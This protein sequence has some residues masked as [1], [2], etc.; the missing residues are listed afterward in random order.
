MVLL[1]TNVSPELSCHL[2]SNSSG[3]IWTSQDTEMSI[4]QEE[5]L[6]KEVVGCQRR[7]PQV[8]QPSKICLQLGIGPEAMN[9]GQ[10]HQTG[11]RN[12]KPLKKRNGGWHGE[13]CQNGQ[14]QY[15]RLEKM[16][17]GLKSFFLRNWFSQLVILIA[18]VNTLMKFEA[19]KFFW[20]RQT[21]MPIITATFWMVSTASAGWFAHQV[22]AL[23]M[24][25]TRTGRSLSHL[26]K[27]RSARPVGTLSV[28]QVLESRGIVKRHAGSN[29]GGLV[30][31]ASV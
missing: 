23:A 18:T 24:F 22:S 1:R 28:S 14:H 10:Y 4:G 7:T 16:K 12:A 5:L 30:V 26:A 27:V 20:S 21:G 29:E 13:G 17:V 6:R 15:H 8:V 19:L 31:K 9:D 2:R 3:S 25:D 11:L